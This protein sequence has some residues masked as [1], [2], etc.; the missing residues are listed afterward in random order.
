[1]DVDNLLAILLILVTF[2]DTVGRAAGWVRTPISYPVRS[3]FSIWVRATLIATAII[4]GLH[5]WWDFDRAP[6]FFQST[7]IAGASAVFI[8]DWREGRRS[9]IRTRFF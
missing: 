1:M 4:S 8:A 2:G 5:S 6:D 7:L 3:M 9:R